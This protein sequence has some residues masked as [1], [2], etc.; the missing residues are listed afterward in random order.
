MW[1][2]ARNLSGSLPKPLVVDFVDMMQGLSKRVQQMT[3][4]SDSGVICH[5][6]LPLKS[7]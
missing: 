5:S 1:N 7:L 3:L 6:A 4:W 2:M